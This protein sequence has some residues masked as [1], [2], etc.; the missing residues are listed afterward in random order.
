VFSS[1]LRGG[2]C[3][4]GVAVV[5]AG[6]CDG[7][8]AA[9]VVGAVVTVEGWL[10]LLSLDNLVA[11]GAPKVEAEPGTAGVD[12]EAAEPFRAGVPPL[13]CPL[14]E[15]SRWSRALSASALRLS[16]SARPNPGPVVDRGI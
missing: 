10:L 6:C 3:G 4:C 8:G 16:A 11:G 15:A 2:S 12:V 5:R 9:A 7:D 13:P 1:D 14:D